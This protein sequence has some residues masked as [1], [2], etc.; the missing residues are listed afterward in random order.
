MPL[1]VFS[2]S[3]AA[4]GLSGEC[5]P[6]CTADMRYRLKENPKRWTHHTNKLPVWSW[7]RKKKSQKAKACLRAHSESK[8]P[9]WG[10]GA[11]LVFNSKHQIRGNGREL[12]WNDCSSDAGL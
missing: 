4:P 6:G 9:M 12:R 5:V 10:W 11:S 7:D 2:V 1:T 8:L 3:S